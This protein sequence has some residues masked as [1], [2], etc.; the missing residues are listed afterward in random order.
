MHLFID[1]NV[2]LEFYSASSD[3]LVELSKLEAMLKNGKAKLWI[4]DQVKREFWKNRS[5]KIECIMRSFENAGGNSIP[6][7]IR[8]DEEF[9]EYLEFSKKAAE[10]K[11]NLI[12]KIRGQIATEETKAD[13]HINTLFLLASEIDTSQ[14]FQQAYERAIR[15]APP[16]KD[17]FIGDRI[18]WL[19]LLSSLPEGSNLHI[20]SNDSDFAKDDRSEEVMPYLKYEWTAKRKGD[21]T[22]WKRLSAFMAK[23]FP[24]ADNAIAVE[25]AIKIESLASSL[26][27]ARTHKIVEEFGDLSHMSDSNVSALAQAVLANNQV[28]WIASDEDVSSFLIQFLSM[29]DKKLDPGVRMKILEY[30]KKT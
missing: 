29:Y 30:T 9:K 16:G 4:T 27:F 11:A 24:D 15:H 28:Y 2:L 19:A 26:S 8:E 5:E 17:E 14:L 6:L 13:K 10:R 23:Q 25:H 12:A 21:V 22:L 20:I 18:N 3:S 1:T 7:L